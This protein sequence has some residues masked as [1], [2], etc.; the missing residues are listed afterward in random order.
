MK[1]KG[2]NKGHHIL[3][4]QM[5]GDTC[6]FTS[7]KLWKTVMIGGGGGGGVSEEGVFGKCCS[8]LGPEWLQ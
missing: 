8:W 2:K 3:G 7:V 5:A 6:G 1:V 4:K